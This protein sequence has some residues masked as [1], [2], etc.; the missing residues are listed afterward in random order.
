MAY[1]NLVLVLLEQGAEHENPQN[2]IP[3]NPDDLQL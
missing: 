3:D 1:C 2:I